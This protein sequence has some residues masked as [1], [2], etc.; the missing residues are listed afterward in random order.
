[1][2][3]AI[4]IDMHVAFER[5]K[6][7]TIGSFSSPYAYAA[8]VSL[9]C[10]A[11]G[12]NRASVAGTE[13]ALRDQLKLQA[14][15]LIAALTEIARKFAPRSGSVAPSHL[16]L[17]AFCK[18]C[19]KATHPVSECPRHNLRTLEERMTFKKRGGE[20][21][22]GCDGLAANNPGGGRSSAAEGAYRQW[23]HPIHGEQQDHQAHRKRAVRD[24]R[25][26]WKHCRGQA[27]VCPIIL[28]W[29]PLDS[30]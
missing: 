18:I 28:S 8:E 24:S 27:N 15:Q 25:R 7:L 12:T 13:P 3:K 19:K 23:M 6:S 21:A 22:G 14:D 20:F 17:V 1:M 16:V 2:I 4:G 26:R 5:L 9:L 11:I 29:G 30:A 10:K